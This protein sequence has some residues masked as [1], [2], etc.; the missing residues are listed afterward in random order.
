MDNR[1]SWPTAVVLI[2]AVVMAVP[3]TLF[4]SKSPQA[5]PILMA[6]VGIGFAVFFTLGKKAKRYRRSAAATEKAD[7][8]ARLQQEVADL[9]ERIE[10]LERIVTDSRYDLKREFDKL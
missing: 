1:M 9:R 5:L 7:D 3:I 4:L 8:Q 6:L 10:T 2:V